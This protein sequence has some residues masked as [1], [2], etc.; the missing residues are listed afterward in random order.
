MF[1]GATQNLCINFRLYW[2][3]N[4]GQIGILDLGTFLSTLY[5][6]KSSLLPSLTKALL[7]PRILNMSNKELRFL[8][9]LYHCLE[10]FKPSLLMHRAVARG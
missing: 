9:A 10:I 7:K 5:Y 6:Q 3:Q 1:E 8:H 2:R 4:F